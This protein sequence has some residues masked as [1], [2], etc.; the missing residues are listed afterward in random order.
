[1]RN[2][3]GYCAPEV[4]DGVLS[5]KA[6]VWAVGIVTVE[7]LTKVRIFNSMEGKDRETYDKIR[8]GLPKDSTFLRDFSHDC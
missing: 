1:M 5:N 4:L 7:L 2:R 8:A 3:A 6:D